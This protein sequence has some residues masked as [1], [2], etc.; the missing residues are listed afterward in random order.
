MT[1]EQFEQAKPCPFCGEGATAEEFLK[2]CE[3]D[4]SFIPVH[5]VIRL[6]NAFAASQKQQPT[7][8]G[9]EEIDDETIAYAAEYQCGTPFSER[10]IGFVKGA[11]WHRSLHAQKIADKMVEERLRGELIKYDKYIGSRGWID[12]YEDWAAITS[13]DEYLKSRER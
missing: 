2:G 10:W 3:H 4:G 1:T 8:E 9:A 6:M 7:A 12:N 5:E 11:K 13:V